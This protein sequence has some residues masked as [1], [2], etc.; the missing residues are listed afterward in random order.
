MDPDP[1]FQKLQNLNPD[2]LNYIFQTNLCLSF[3]LHFPCLYTVRQS[4]LDPT[5]FKKQTST[6][7]IRNTAYLFSQ[8]QQE[9]FLLENIE[10]FKLKNHI[11]QQK[12]ILH[13]LEVGH[14]GVQ[15]GQLVSVS[16]RTK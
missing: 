9:R 12:E 7:R 4:F 8:N 13:H 1:T 10:L 16:Q 5:N 2:P 15:R 3:P 14:V 6:A 11:N